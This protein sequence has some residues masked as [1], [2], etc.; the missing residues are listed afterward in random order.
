MFFERKNIIF[1][2][3]LCI[4]TAI[5]VAYWRV[6]HALGLLIYNTSNPLS[7]RVGVYLF[8]GTV[9][10]HEIMAPNVDYAI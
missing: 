10:R 8:G 6:V 4:V 7:Y 9:W 2:K 5:L 3:L 1:K